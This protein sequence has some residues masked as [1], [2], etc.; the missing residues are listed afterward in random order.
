MKFSVDITGNFVNVKGC[1][2]SQKYELE[3]ECGKCRTIKKQLQIDEN[4]TVSKK[5]IDTHKTA[6]YNLIYMCS[7][8]TEIC[9]KI[10]EPDTFIT[11]LNNDNENPVKAHPIINN[12]CCVSHL[13]SDGGFIKCANKINLTIVPENSDYAKEHIDITKNIAVCKETTK[14]SF[15]DNFSLKINEIN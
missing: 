13:W 11:I 6:T 9:I 1:F 4:K 7:C 3:V 10:S 8:G 5:I 2:I 14:E 12:R 15:I